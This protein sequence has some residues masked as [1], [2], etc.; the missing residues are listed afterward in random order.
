MRPLSLAIGPKAIPT[1]PISAVAS[2]FSASNFANSSALDIS[3]SLCLMLYSVPSSSQVSTQFAHVSGIPTE[4]TAPSSFAFVV[5]SSSVTSSFTSF[6][7]DELSEQAANME[8]AN[9][10]IKPFFHNF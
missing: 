10:P 7:P 2:S 9:A 3:V 1:S 4:L 5:I 6:V 8:M